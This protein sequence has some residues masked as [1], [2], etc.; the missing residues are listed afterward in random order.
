MKKK[1]LFFIFLFSIS[2]FYGQIALLDSVSLAVYQEYTS[3]EEAL[4]NPEDVIKLTLKRNKFKAFP[5]ELYQFKNLQ[6][7]DLTKNNIKELPDSIVTFKNL[8]YLILSKTNLQSLPNNIGELKNL[9]HLNANQ[10]SIG[11]LPYSF[12]NLENLEV[13]DL[14]SNELEYFPETMVKLKKLKLLDLRNILISKT[15]QEQIQMMI[16]N[17]LIQFSPPC[18]CGQ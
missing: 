13:A 12:G 1:F 10:N 14:W 15:V 2:R 5:S 11:R 7:L 4:K 16:P 9:K 6:Y 8:Q 17:T 3:L 18:N